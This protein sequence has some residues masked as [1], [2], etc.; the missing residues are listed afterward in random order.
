MKSLKCLAAICIALCSFA[1]Q[2]RASF[3]IDIGDVVTFANTSGV[4]V[5]ILV[6]TPI[7]AVSQFGTFNLAIDIL[8]AGIALPA[9]LAVGTPETAGGTIFASPT[10][11]HTFDAN[12]GGFNGI[13]NANAATGV[14]LVPGVQ[15]T[16]F[17]LRFDVGNVA[18]GTVFNINFTQVAPN[19]FSVTDR[20]GTAMTFNGA[21]PNSFFLQNGSIMVA[22]AVP[23]PSSMLLAGGVAALAGFRSWRKR[24]ATANA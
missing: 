4:V 11:N 24:R 5:P 8:P 23:E 16:A 21:G 20:A 6:S 18:P 15:S 13:L 9:G 2:T 22:A 10:V 12:F 3:T 14:D 17:N 19:G 7:G 1:G